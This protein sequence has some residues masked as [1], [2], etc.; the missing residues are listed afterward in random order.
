[1]E[2][3]SPMQPK[4]EDADLY[5]CLMCPNRFKKENSDTIGTKTFSFGM[6][7]LSFNDQ[8]KRGAHQG[9]EPL[10]EEA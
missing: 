4:E 6:S 8:T 3:I 7:E 1:M 5:S 10:S 2:Y 9:K